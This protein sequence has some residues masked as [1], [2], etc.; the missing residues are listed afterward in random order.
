MARTRS[1]IFHSTALRCAAVK[2][3]RAALEGPWSKF[4]AAQRSAVLWKISDLVL[5][6]F[7]QLCEL[8]ILDNGLPTPL[9]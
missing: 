6:N 8:E 4:T 5:A 7:Q 1:E 3:A 2:A 9:A